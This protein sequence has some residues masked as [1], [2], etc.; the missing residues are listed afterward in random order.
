MAIRL[1]V[2]A[3]M[4]ALLLIVTGG[5]AFGFSN[6]NG[7]SELAPGLNHAMKACNRVIERQDEKAYSGGQRATGDVSAPTNCDHYWSD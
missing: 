6:G 4:A 5:G 1:Y 3:Y 2:V 7:N